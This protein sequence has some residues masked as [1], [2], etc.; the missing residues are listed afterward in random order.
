MEEIRTGSAE[1][2]LARILESAR[3]AGPV[4]STWNPR[5]PW[6]GCVSGRTGCCGSGSVCR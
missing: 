5:L 1:M 3:A 6:C 4:I 2:V